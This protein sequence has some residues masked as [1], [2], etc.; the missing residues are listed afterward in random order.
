MRTIREFLPKANVFSFKDVSSEIGMSLL[1]KEIRKLYEEFRDSLYGGEETEEMIEDFHKIDT[2]FMNLMEFG[3][4][5]QQDCEVLL[6][7]SGSADPRESSNLAPFW[8]REVIRE[9]TRVYE[10]Y[11]LK[12]VNGEAKPEFKKKSPS[13]R[14]ALDSSDEDYEKS[15][16]TKS[17]TLVISKLKTS[18]RASPSSSAKVI[19]PSKGL[20]TTR[21][22]RTPKESQTISPVVF[23]P[24]METPVDVIE[25]DILFVACQLINRSEGDLPVTNDRLVRDVLRVAKQFKHMG[26]TEAE[27]IRTIGSVF[28]ELPCVSHDFINNFT[29]HPF[30]QFFESLKI[31]DE[32]EN[33][34]IRA[35]ILRDK[36]MKKCDTERLQNDRSVPIDED[37]SSFHQ[38]NV[39]DESVEEVIEKMEQSGNGDLITKLNGD[40]SICGHEVEMLEEDLLP[41]PTEIS[42]IT[43]KIV[44]CEETKESLKSIGE[45]LPEPVIVDSI[46]DEMKELEARVKKQLEE[47]ELHKDNS[48]ILGEGIKHELRPTALDRKNFWQSCG[49]DLPKWFPGFFTVFQDSFN[50]KPTQVF[51]PDS[52]FLHAWRSMAPMIEQN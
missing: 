5:P 21:S 15:I 2:C 10:K 28:W 29:Y 48:R 18:V 33:L 17:P 44:T 51:S 40:V 12:I 42:E 30:N 41:V 43:Y 1:E 22:P 36:N 34:M 35:N 8:C 32:T 49:R 7:A 46:N 27:A 37:F 31:S 45:F 26:L 20:S 14:K 13:P 38:L 52:V 19:S 4:I 9:L 16:S 39:S 11:M 50:Y 24:G 47:L 23:L 3:N 6:N 25:R